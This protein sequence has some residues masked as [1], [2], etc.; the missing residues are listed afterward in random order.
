MDGT[1]NRAFRYARYLWSAYDATVVDVPH[2][3]STPAPSGRR[4]KDTA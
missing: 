2:P 1:G 3:Q 4:R